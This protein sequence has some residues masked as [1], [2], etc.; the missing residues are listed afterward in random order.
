MADE[1]KKDG[2]TKKPASARK[3]SASK[4]AAEKSTKSRTATKKDVSESADE[5]TAVAKT[6]ADRKSSDAAAITMSQPSGD[7]KNVKLPI[8]I[9]IGVAALVC[10]LLIGRFLLTGINMGGV[11]GKT[12]LSESELDTTVG[13]Y[14]YDGKS[15]NISARDA[16]TATAS[17][18][19]VKDSDGNYTMPSAD[20]VLSVA[21]NGVLAKAVEAAGITVSDDDV[22]SYAE[23]TLGSSDYATIA[24]QYSLDE[25]TTKSILKQS[26]GVKKLYD[27]IVTTSTGTAPTA[28]A[29][30]ATGQEDVATADYYNYIIGLFGDEWDTTTNTW[31]RTDGPYY[32]AMSDQTFTDN[33]ATY[34]QA[35]TAYYVAYQQYS[36]TA[37]S[38]S[39]QWTSYVNGLLS[40]ASIQISSLVS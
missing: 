29:T 9:I 37:S 34:S 30:A 32:A 16:I 7:Q 36:Q 17:L 10:G 15:Y 39:T 1:E 12:T 4:A 25:D 19:S 5:K 14:T 33:T 21:R 3:T 11:S 27:T 24:S 13:S 2:A 6:A 23:S 31:A 18:D 38:A 20:N 26:A 28:P 35:Q 8:A 22:A 40:K